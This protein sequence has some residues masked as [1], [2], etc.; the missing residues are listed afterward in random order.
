M[1]YLVFI[2]YIIIKYIFVKIDYLQYLGRYVNVLRFKMYKLSIL[3]NHG[4]FNINYQ[5]YCLNLG[6]C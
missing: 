4:Q 3:I 1:Y 2:R 6:L 5:K